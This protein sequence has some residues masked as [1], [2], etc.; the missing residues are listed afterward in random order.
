MVMSDY[1]LKWRLSELS[2]WI[3]EGRKF[4]NNYQNIQNISTIS[5][6]LV[7]DLVE[8]RFE[9]IDK[10][11]KLKERLRELDHANIY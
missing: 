8:E 3:Q 11:K 2:S 4:P 9:L 7:D 5:L 6:N 1:E 10:V